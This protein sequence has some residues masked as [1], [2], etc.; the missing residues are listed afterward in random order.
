MIIKANLLL[1][2]SDTTVQMGTEQNTMET[3]AKEDTGISQPYDTLTFH[4]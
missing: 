3:F 1:V 4:F 2:S